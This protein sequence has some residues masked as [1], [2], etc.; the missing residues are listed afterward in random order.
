MPEMEKSFKLTNRRYLG[1]K[2]KLLSFIHTTIEKEGIAF[3]S[4]LDLFAGTG[5][6]ANSFNDGKHKV[7]VNDMRLWCFLW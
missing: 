5:S 3:N 2:T 1:S 7:I 6:V 4:I